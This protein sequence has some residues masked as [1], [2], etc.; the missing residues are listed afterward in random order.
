MSNLIKMNLYRLIR[1][2]SYYIIL[3]IL[4]M[5]AVMVT[6][7]MGV[8]PEEY[9]SKEIAIIPNV[10]VAFFR[11]SL[12]PMVITIGVGIFVCSDYTSGYMKN[13]ASS[14][15]S[16][17]NIAIAY[18][19]TWAIGVAIY[20]LVITALL[21][22][23]SK[24]FMSEASINNISQLLQYLALNYF[25]NVVMVALAVLV[26]VISKR[27]S[28]TIIFMVTAT[29]FLPLIYMLLD[30]KLKVNLIPYSPISNLSSIDFTNM[31]TYGTVFIS[32]AILLVLYSAISY[33]VCAKKDIA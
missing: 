25:L 21:C 19:I 3:G 12:I 26:S 5:F 20:Y 2:K 1:T 30:S 24:I 22:L 27:S 17:G 15:K 6:Y 13:I 31:N 4:G 8:Y 9:M 18:I 11:G 28:G 32:G 7:S 29:N 16:R 23:S 33:Y 10:I 14:V